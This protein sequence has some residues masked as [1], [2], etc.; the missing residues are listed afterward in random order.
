MREHTISKERGVSEAIGYLI[1]LGLVVTGIGLV[2]LYG[3]PI[4]MQQQGL[5]NMRNM[6]RTMIVIQ[7]DIKSLTYTLDNFKE[8]DFQVGGGPIMI[9]PSNAVPQAFDISWGGSGTGLPQQSTG[10]LSFGE[11][12]YFSTQDNAVVAYEN[13]A[14]IKKYLGQN[15]ILLAGPRWYVAKSSDGTTT[16]VINLVNLVSGG[17]LVSETGAGAIRTRYSSTNISTPVFSGSPAT[18]RNS[19]R[20]TYRPDTVNVTPNGYAQAWRMYLTD[21]S[22]LGLVESP[23]GSNQ[24]IFPPS[25]YPSGINNVVVKKYDVIV[26]M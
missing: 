21:P 2:T 17:K 12:R 13:G 11:I 18:I 22:A 10:W 14:V 5:A 8:T 15:A 4:L 23:T 25:I 16:L 26:E 9:L 20:I 24:Y 19:I 6:E 7:N 3:Y 1:I